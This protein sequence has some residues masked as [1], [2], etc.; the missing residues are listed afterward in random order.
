M[1]ST[2]QFWVAFLREIGISSENIVFSSDTSEEQGREFGKGRGTV[3]CC[4]PVK[5]MSGHYG[6]LIFGQKRKLHIIMSPMIY[7][8]PSFMRGH[9]SENLACTRVMAGPENI[10]AGFVK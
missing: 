8:L 5:A 9:V 6:E 3:D 7:S 10:R 4:Y 2:H 1:W